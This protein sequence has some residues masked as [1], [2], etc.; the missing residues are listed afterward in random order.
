M[1]APK[2]FSF[3]GNKTGRSYRVYFNS[4]RDYWYA[5]WNDGQSRRRVALG[6]TSKPEAEEAVRLLDEPPVKPVQSV[7]LTWPEFQA[8]Y[9]KYKQVQ[10][11]AVRTVERYKAALDAFNR[12]CVT[13]RIDTVDKI[14][15]LV[16][17]GYIP[18]RTQTEKMKAKTA[19]CDALIIKNALQWGSTKA[20]GLLKENPALDWE[21]KKPIVPKR[22]AYTVNEVAKLETGV[23]YWLKPVVTTLAWS[24]LRIGELVNLRWKDVDLKAGVLHI[25]VRDDWKPKGR[26]DRMVP[27]H[28]KVESVLKRQPV[29][30]MAF[31]G[32]CG[33]HIKETYALECLKADQ[34]KLGLPGG[35]LHG[36]RRFFATTM[37]QAGV[38]V[39]TVRQ[40]GGWKS[41]ETMLR[42]LADVDTKDS[43]VAMEQAV[44]RLAT[45]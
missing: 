36:F 39:E 22:R 28:P 40:W 11:K 19:H 43:V 4:Q 10:D 26:A 45:A 25:R 23:R 1:S 42:Y 3:F 2:S 27:L 34:V 32:P 16:L 12:Y 13:L 30:E 29:G 35:D 6:V 14:T 18:Y 31:P 5:A 7:T 38:P 37:M 15:L 41:L 17:E 24:G 20:R 8:L 21:T 44:K 33:G 9:L